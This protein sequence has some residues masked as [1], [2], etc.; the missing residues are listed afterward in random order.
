MARS[1][2]T[3]GSE[4][5]GPLVLLGVVPTLRRVARVFGPL[6]PAPESEDLELEEEEPSSGSSSDASSGWEPGDGGFFDLP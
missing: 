1:F 3:R 6:E 4:P 5:T 2:V